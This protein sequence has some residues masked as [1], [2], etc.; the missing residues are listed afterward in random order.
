MTN[1]GV[2]GPGRSTLVSSPLSLLDFAS[3]LAFFA[4]APFAIVVVAELF[5]V[6]GALIDVGLA[7]LVFLASEAVR[8][9]SS[10]SR[11]LAWLLSEALAFESHYRET[12][13]RPFLYYVAY[14]LLFPYWL[15]VREARR[16]FLMYRSYTLFGLLL[17]LASLGWQYLSAWAPELTFRAYLPFVLLSLLV[18]TLLVLAL[19]M[20][21]ATTVVW[22]H[23]SFRRGRLLVVLLTGLASTCASLAYV[24]RRREP[25]VSYATRERVR[26]RTEVAAA[27]AHRVLGRAARA[28]LAAVSRSNVEGD[29]RV[30]GE[31]L[32]KARAALRSFYKADEAQAF[33]IWA[34]PRRAPNLLVIYFEGRPHT[35]PIWV[36]V[37]RDGSEIRRADQLPAGAFRAMRRASGESDAALWTW[38]A[39]LDAWVE[40]DGL[41]PRRPSVNAR[42]RPDAGVAPPV[43]PASASSAP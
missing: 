19:L 6:R 28:A 40:D 9:W 7:L 4:L 27:R 16:E 21:I 17:L 10:R 43:A 29:G 26:L 3:R 32:E 23:A 30:E 1:L 12:L 33:D 37:R 11:V 14:P 18:E 42:S 24:A 35:R 41:S 5:P 15:W 25:V 22:Y 8:K 13:P 36:A 38:P 39:E 31:P 2:D 20:P 34:S